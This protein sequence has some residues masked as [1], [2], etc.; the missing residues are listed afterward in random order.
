MA[1]YLM[2]NFTFLSAAPTSSLQGKLEIGV[3]VADAALGDNAGKVMGAVLALL[4]ISTVSAMTMAGPRVLQVIGE[5]FTVFSKLARCNA[6]GIPVNAVLFQGT[7]AMFFII[8]ATFESVLIF[9]SFVLAINTLFSV[10]GVFVLRFK[11]LNNR[12]RK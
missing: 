7:L 10:L 9:S 11:K 12:T 2:L 1:L 5:D 3:I 8:S 6:Q 4:L